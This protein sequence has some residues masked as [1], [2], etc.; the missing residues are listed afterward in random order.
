MESAWIWNN[1][2]SDFL[3]RKTRTNSWSSFYHFALIIHVVRTRNCE[4]TVE[5][6][7]LEWQNAKTDEKLKPRKKVE[8]D[9]ITTDVKSAKNFQPLWAIGNF[10]EAINGTIVTFKFFPWKM[11]CVRKIT[12]VFAF[13]SSTSF[14]SFEVSLHSCVPSD[15]NAIPLYF[16]STFISSI[17]R[18]WCCYFRGRILYLLWVTLTW[19]WIA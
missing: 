9:V 10:H 2:K 4:I 11:I 14:L 16:L 6:E 1:T 19:K 12:D 18:I 17:K 8:G 3:T 5:F 7:L 13:L 15:E